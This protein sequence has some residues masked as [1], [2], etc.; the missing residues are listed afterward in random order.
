MFIL[1]TEG[2]REGIGLTPERSCDSQF[3]WRAQG[4]RDAGTLGKMY[5][6]PYPRKSQSSLPKEQM[7]TGSRQI[8]KIFARVSRDNLDKRRPDEY[9][10]SALP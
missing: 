6:T 2:R 9:T 10:F 7:E 3:N 1:S 5:R 4:K 8:G